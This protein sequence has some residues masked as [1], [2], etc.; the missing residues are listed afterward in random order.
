MQSRNV[1]DFLTEIVLHKQKQLD[2]IC[3]RGIKILF[4]GWSE[5]LPYIKKSREFIFRIIWTPISILKI[6]GAH[7]E[8]IS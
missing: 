7:K 8:I 1:H 2:D 4:S 6:Q 5:S 3:V